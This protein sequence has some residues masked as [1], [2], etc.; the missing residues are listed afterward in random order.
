MSRYRYWIGVLAATLLGMI[1]TVAGVGK[2]LSHSS[3]YEAFLFPSFLPGAVADYAY[4][5]FPYLELTIG[6][7]LICGIAVK[8]TASLSMGMVACFIASNLYLLSNGVGT[9]G[10]CF[11]V[12]GGLTVYAALV[13][14]GLMAIMTVIILIT[15]QG[16]YFNGTPWYLTG[17]TATRSA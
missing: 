6:L 4:A 13:L 5:V 14:D 9:C 7:L 1:F 3:S 8:F 11:G 12:A 17:H 10:E 16:K 2:L 15:Y